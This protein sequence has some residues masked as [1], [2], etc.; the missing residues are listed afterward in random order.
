M[1]AHVPVLPCLSSIETEEALRRE[2]EAFHRQWSVLQTLPEVIH[3]GIE[4]TFC[5]L[6]P[7]NANS[8][9]DFFPG[10]PSFNISTEQLLTPHLLNSHAQR[11]R[12]QFILWLFGLTGQRIQASQCVCDRSSS[13]T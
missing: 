10:D 12:Q 5:Q 2:R 4:L 11:S 3:G 6:D 1:C 8:L 9:D 13:S 7:F